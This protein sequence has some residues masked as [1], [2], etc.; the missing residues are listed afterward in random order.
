MLMSDE[1]VARYGIIYDSYITVGIRRAASEVIIKNKSVNAVDVQFLEKQVENLACF[2]FL[3]LICQIILKIYHYYFI[4]NTKVV[5][6]HK[7]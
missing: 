4:I 6:N 3:L 7:R 2:F 1:G 5:N